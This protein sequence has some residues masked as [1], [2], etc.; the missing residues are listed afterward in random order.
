MLL[1]AGMGHAPRPSRS[2]RT[3]PRHWQPFYRPPRAYYQHYYPV[4]A[5]PVIFGV[6]Q[7]PSITGERISNELLEAEIVPDDGMGDLGA[8]SGRGR[9][10]DVTSLVVGFALGFLFAK[11][12]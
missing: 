12:C 5:V 8:A 1:D 10:W 9:A 11:N 7:D 6:W 2:G 4:N 3:W